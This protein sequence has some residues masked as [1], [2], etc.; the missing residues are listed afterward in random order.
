M[1]A[2]TF[3]QLLSKREAAVVGQHKIAKKYHLDANT[4]LIPIGSAA[5][6]DDMARNPKYERKFKPK[7][8]QSLTLV[9]KPGIK[10]FFVC[11]AANALKPTD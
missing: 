1:A 11:N 4:V 6:S 5:G 2:I 8:N 10:F 3:G 9:F 7:G